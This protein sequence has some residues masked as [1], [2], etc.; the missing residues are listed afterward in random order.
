M[1]GV[2]YLAIGAG[3]YVPVLFLIN[4]NNAEG[5]RLVGWADPKTRRAVMFDA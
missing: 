3:R 1:C 2:W 5:N 4:N